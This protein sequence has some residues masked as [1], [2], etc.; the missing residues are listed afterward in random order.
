MIDYNDYHPKWRLISW[1]IRIRRAG[2]RCE[3]ERPDGSRCN[4]EN[5]KPHPDTG[6]IVVLTVAHLDRDRNNNR[7]SNLKAGC[8]RCH[9]NHDRKQHVWNRKYGRQTKYKNHKLD[10]I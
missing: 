7:F 6:S 2:N 4:A 1:L 5:H 10:F 8:Q 9:L 3:F